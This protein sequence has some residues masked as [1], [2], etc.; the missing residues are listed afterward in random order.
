[1]PVKKSSGTNEPI[2]YQRGTGEVVH[3]QG[4]NFQFQ[5]N[6]VCMLCAVRDGTRNYAQLILFKKDT[7]TL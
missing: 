2:P 3:I 1:M 4:V 5:I 7:R 6:A